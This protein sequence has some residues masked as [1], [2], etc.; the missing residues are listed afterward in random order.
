MD[1]VQVSILNETHQIIPQRLEAELLDFNTYGLNQFWTTY[2]AVA[3]NTID[4]DFA[5]ELQLKRINIS[6][7][8]V[9]ERQLLREKQIVDGWEH[10]LDDNG[11]VAKLCKLLLLNPVTASITTHTLSCNIDTGK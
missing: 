3:D 2:H 4:Y 7:E 10:L 8:R 9:N 11:N 1:Y 6:P 5:M